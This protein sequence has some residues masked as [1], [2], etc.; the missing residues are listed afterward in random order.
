MLLVAALRLHNAQSH[1]LAREQ[2][3]RSFK[4]QATQQARQVQL[5]AGAMGP[6]AVLPLTC[7]VSQGAH[8]SRQKMVGREAD[9]LQPRQGK[10]QLARR[11]PP[12][13][14]LP[15]PAQ[16]HAP[17][18]HLPGPTPAIGGCGWRLLGQI[19]LHKQRIKA[20]VHLDWVA[21]LW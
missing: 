11:L 6:A 20:V 16:P 1:L 9:T 3:T 2:C 10:P 19:R 4:P 7:S 18:A 14:Q 21:V 17:A 8:N 13:L 15:S 5:P 12:E